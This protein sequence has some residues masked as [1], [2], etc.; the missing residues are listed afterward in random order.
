[1]I[2]DCAVY[3]EG[4]RR[5]GK[6]PLA[7]ACEAS[8]QPGAFVWVGVVEPGAEEF[9]AIARE[10]SLHPLA[11]E[12][13]VMAHQ[14][15]KLEQY[16]ETLLVVLKPIRYIDSDEL[17][18]TD[19]V[20]LFVNPSFLVTVRHG[21][22][23]A[24]AEVRKAAEADPGLLRHGPPAALHAIVDRVVDDYELALT[25]IVTDV[26]EVEAQVFSDSR[27]NPAQRI[28]RLE[29]ELLEFQR[30]AA[31]LAPALD[32]FSRGRHPSIPQPMHDYFR[33]VYDHL[34]RVQGRIEALR[35]LLGNALQANLTQ[36]TVRQNE[37]MRKISAWVAIAAVPTMIAG[38][39]GMNFDNMPE[40]HWDFGYPLAVGVMAAIC[41]TLYWRFKR[42][43]WL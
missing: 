25:E 27:E 23:V 36:V 28:Y 22:A 4:T 10:F 34:L 9:D 41:A 16:G 42:S 37:D 38:I 35:E 26:Q 21:P 39:Y 33:D 30:A 32:A 12:D 13:A 7:E 1:L 14:R 43:G 5:P 15:P 40:L 2:V 17:I 8:E 31:P 6:L 3:D 18:E 19:E 29:R 20:A 24:L 11:V